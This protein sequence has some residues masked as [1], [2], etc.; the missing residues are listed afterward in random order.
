MPN[1]YSY[2]LS[3]DKKTINNNELFNYNI[4]YNYI[5]TLNDNPL[6]NDIFHQ[7]NY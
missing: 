4:N 3:T 1:D 7:K 6:V 5:T 2:D